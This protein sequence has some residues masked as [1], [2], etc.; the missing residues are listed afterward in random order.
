[1]AVG[2]FL[3]QMMVQV[4]ERPYE[5]SVEVLD[6]VQ[7]VAAQ[8]VVVVVVEQIHLSKGRQQNHHSSCPDVLS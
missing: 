1:M 7:T 8:E 5:V 2:E 4:V 3:D 6:Q